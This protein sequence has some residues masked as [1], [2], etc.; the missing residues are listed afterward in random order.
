MENS[1]KS[2]SVIIQVFNEKSTIEKVI[3]KISTVQLPIEMEIVV[4]DDGSTDGTADV[5]R[6]QTESKAVFHFSPVN[7]GKGSAIRMGLKVAKGDIVLIQDADLEY[8]PTD[9]A[10]LLEPILRGESEVVYGSRFL[11]SNYIP[12]IRR[13]ANRFLTILTNLLYKSSLTDMETGFKV[14]TSNVASKLALQSDGFE[15]EPEIT[16]RILQA[17][18]KIVEVPVSYNPRTKI[19]GKKI[20]WKDGFIAIWMLLK[21]R[22]EKQ[23]DAAEEY[24][25]ENA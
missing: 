2:L 23:R 1:Y 17:G 6:S 18:F 11:Q 24:S 8:N 5:L 22:F 13:L 19:E 15:I 20:S 12:F 16:S 9:Y 3:D 7:A 4:V 21:C 14:F 25:N 10:T